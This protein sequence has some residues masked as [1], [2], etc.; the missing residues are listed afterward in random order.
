MKTETVDRVA[1]VVDASVVVRW[2][3]P[4]DPLISAARRVHETF[5]CRAPTLLLAETAN[6]LWKY[7]RVSRLTPE[8][9]VEGVEFARDQVDLVEDAVLV[10]SAQR[11]SSEADHP[12]YECFYV[13]AALRDGIPLITADG[14]LVRKFDGTAGLRL[15]PLE[16]LN[17]AAVQ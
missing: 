3:V 11:L 16:T 12:V 14:R 17:R 1:A 5:D 4:D 13:A 15:I 6:A 2:F 9:A 10:R 8:E 7:T